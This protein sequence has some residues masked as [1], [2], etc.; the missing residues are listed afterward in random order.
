MSYLLINDLSH[1]FSGLCIKC[2]Q[3]ARQAGVHE[4]AVPRRGRR[5]RAS[6]DRETIETDPARP[7]LEDPA[8]PITDPREPCE[9]FRVH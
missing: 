3:M 2:T 5:P 6:F 9:R 1:L 8:D 4:D 7:S